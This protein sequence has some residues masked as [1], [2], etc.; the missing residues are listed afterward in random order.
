M[1][2][3]IFMVTALDHPLSTDKRANLRPDHLRWIEKEAEAFLMAGPLRET[4]DGP[5]IGSHLM[6]RA[7][8]KAALSAIL[9]S[10]P[11]AVGDLFAS[12]TISHFQPV[13]GAWLKT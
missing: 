7:K 6:V 8:N 13:M 5:V 4:A 10:D 12:V 3:Q 1:A 11:Y 2:D 9:A